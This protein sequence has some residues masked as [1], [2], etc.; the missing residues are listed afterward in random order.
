MALL[1][2][3]KTVSCLASTMADQRAYW[4]AENWAV[5]MACQMVAK[6]VA[7]LVARK[8]GHWDNLWA[9]YLAECWVSRRAD[10]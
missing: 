3:A 5:L 9:A 1:S 6:T 8:A 2:V 4:K 10:L 7:C